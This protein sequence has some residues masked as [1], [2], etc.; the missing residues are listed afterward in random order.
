MGS[1]L[2]SVQVDDIGKDCNESGYEYL[3]KDS[4]PISLLGLVDDMIGVNEAGYKAKQMNAV[5]SVKTVE[6]YLQFGV[7]KCKSTHKICYYHW[8]EEHIEN[9]KTGEQDLVEH[10]GGTII[11]CIPVRSQTSDLQIGFFICPDK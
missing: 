11:I 6:Q 3:Y 5:I 4:L 10:F 9:S 7:T 8:T 1:I 2:A